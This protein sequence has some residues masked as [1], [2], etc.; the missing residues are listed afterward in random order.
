MK[1]SAIFLCFWLEPPACSPGTHWRRFGLWHSSAPGDGEIGASQGLDNLFLGGA[2]LYASKPPLRWWIAVLCAAIWTASLWTGFRLASAT[3]GAYVIL[4]IGLSPVIRLPKV[5][6]WETILRDLHLGVARSAERDPDARLSHN[7]V[8]KYNYFYT[9]YST[10]SRFILAVCGRPCVEPEKAT[11]LDDL[12]WDCREIGGQAAA[13]T[14]GIA[15]LER[16]PIRLRGTVLL[17]R[18]GWSSP[19]FSA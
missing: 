8:S 14:G 6:G 18:V 13:A 10:Y 5:T 17:L 16:F 19:P 15:S 9:Y 4:Y 1:P 2:V 11:P 7:M 3:V 12:G